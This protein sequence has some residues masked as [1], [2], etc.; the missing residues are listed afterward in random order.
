MSEPAKEESKKHRCRY[1][2]RF[3]KDPVSIARGAGPVCWARAEAA[4]AVAAGLDPK[5]KK[6]PRKTAGKGKGEAATDPHQ[7]SFAFT[8]LVEIGP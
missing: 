5:A 8:L 2:P 4:A 3:L 7:L 6:K 1:C